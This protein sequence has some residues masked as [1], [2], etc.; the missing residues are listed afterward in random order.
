MT[1]RIEDLRPGDVLLDRRMW[2][3]RRPR[4]RSLRAR[5]AWLKHHDVEVERYN[6]AQEPGAFVGNAKV[7]AALNASG[8][9]CLPIVFVD[10]EP[11]PGVGYPK[12][13][14]LMELL[15]LK[16]GE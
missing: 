14:Q 9:E 12:R 2:A 5:V 10:G 8:P 11:I 16:V 13:E 1:A 15:G 3:D 7:L 4:T 6:L